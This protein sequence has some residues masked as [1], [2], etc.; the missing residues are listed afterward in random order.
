MKKGLLVIISSPS[1]GGKDSVIN[2]LLEKIP[3]SARLVTTTTRAP[4]VGEK[5]GVNYNFLSVEEFKV[6]MAADGFLETNFYADNYYGVEKQVLKQTLSQHAVVF[7]NIEVNGKQNVDK[8]GI[9][10]LSIFLMPESFET[11]KKRIIE[12]GGV[13]E[14]RLEERL[15]T[16]EKEM[17]V[18]P[19]YDYRIVNKEGKLS[20]TIA[21]AQKIIEDKLA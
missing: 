15:L 12:R 17:Q 9:K 2:G 16:A 6:R 1:G 11:L 14:K 3:D 13:D 7:S 19:L 18:A 5:D 21:K 10:N 4:R 20:E 8:A